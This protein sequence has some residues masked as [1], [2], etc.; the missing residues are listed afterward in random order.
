[1]FSSFRVSKLVLILMLCKFTSGCVS[2]EPVSYSSL[3]SSIHLAHNQKADSDKY[4]YVY[5]TQTD[6][7]SYNKAIINPVAIY[8]GSDHQF[9]DMAENDKASLT[10]YMQ[11]QFSEKTAARFA[12]VNASSP[13]TLRVRLT[14]TGATANTPV[15]GTLSRFDMLG[16]AYNGVQAIR[17]KEGSMTGSVIF[18]VEIYDAPTNRLLMAYVSKQYPNAMNIAASIGPLNASMSG[19]EN[20]AE[21]FIGQL[22]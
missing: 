20:G 11:R 3:P 8:R 18:A 5:S 13:G 2:A 1:M 22:R 10:S 17:G 9:G 4:P 16:G 15:L 7:N 12:L 19:I 21:A 14:L 6:W